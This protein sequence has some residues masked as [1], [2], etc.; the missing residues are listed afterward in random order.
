MVR[1]EGNKIYYVV[2]IGDESSD[3]LVLRKII[4]KMIPQAIIESLYTW[5][6][7]Q[8]FVNSHK[9][10]PDLI[11]VDLNS[12]KEKVEATHATIRQ[13]FDL[14]KV[15]L[16]TIG[17]EAEEMVEIKKAPNSAYFKRSYNFNSI[18]WLARNLQMKWISCLI[19][20]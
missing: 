19:S 3:H 5:H 1:A 10:T 11:F 14:E 16:I 15:P 13:N 18:E 9:Q 2:I 17:D 20:I 7:T 12:E 8:A 6:D 4:N